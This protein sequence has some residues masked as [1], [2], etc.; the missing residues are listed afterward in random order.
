[1]QFFQLIPD[2]SRSWYEPGPSGPPF[3][4]CS[5]DLLQ[6]RLEQMWNEQGLPEL[7]TLAKPLVD[8]AM[9][10]HNQYEDGRE[11]LS[12]DMYVMY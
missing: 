8:L 2:E 6:E 1:M 11:T 9:K 7:E 4:E 12:D 5:Q 10:F 3:V